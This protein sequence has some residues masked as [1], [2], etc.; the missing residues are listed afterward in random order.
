MPSR[1]RKLSELQDHCSPAVRS[2]SPGAA[3]GALAVVLVWLRVLLDA[4]PAAAQPASMQMPLPSVAP[5]TPWRPLP[6]AA[7]TLTRIGVGSCLHQGRPQPVWKGVVASN[8]QLFLMI[9]DNVYGDATDGTIQPLVRAYRKQ[10]RQTEFAEARA[11][12]P[13]L[14]VWDDHDF[15]LNDASVDFPLAIESKALFHDFW[16]IRPE[17]DKGIYTSKTFGPPGQR[18][19]II[20]LDVRS[21]RSTFRRAET[22]SAK[23]RYAP[24]PDPDKTML[25][26]EQWSWLENALRE[27]AEIRLLVSSTQV[28]AMGHQHERWGNLPAER[29]RL[30]AL[31]RRM[32][33]RGIVLLSGDRHM[34]AFYEVE[35]V[36]GR[37]LAEMT[38]SALN[39]SSNLSKDK[40][41][42]PLV[43][44]PYHSDS[45]GLVEIDWDA[46]TVRLS[47][48]D[49][50]GEEA[51]ALS[52]SFAGLGLD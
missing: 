20:L 29:A 39:R 33:A 38:A 52:L 45:F 31:L 3:I 8:P 49:V 27:P 30:L 12:F 47:I 6:S 43:G 35:A 10:G 37:K 19:Q 22:S 42:P 4:G 11:A 26:P 46:R 40:R 34:S 50:A 51:G 32:D 5:S 16:G 28:L 2:S 15:G 21:F 24:D 9:G 44:E 25:G 13:F 23:P 41:V 18:V 1:E 17:R 14:A 36:K 48:R 7:A